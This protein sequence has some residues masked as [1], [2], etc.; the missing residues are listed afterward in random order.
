MICWQKSKAGFTLIELMI[1]V[2]LMLVLVSAVVMVFSHTSTV[3][4]IS[5]AKMSVYQ[6]ARAALDIM[7]KELTS[8]DNTPLTGYTG[9]AYD[10]F[11][12]AYGGTVAAGGRFQF[13]TN[14]FWIS[15]SSRQ[16]GMAVVDYSLQMVPGYNVYNI[17]R[18]V[19]RI[20]ISGT[21][22][23]LVDVSN[24]ILAQYVANDPN[25]FQIDC[26]EYDAAGSQ[27]RQYPTTAYPQTQPGDNKLPGA[28]RIT[29]KFTD[30]ERRILRSLSRTIWI[31]KVSS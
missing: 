23:T 12:V 16:N 4:S 20:N 28:V 29:I 17:M 10:G 30:R 13:K 8:S 21:T 27:W 14:T 1:S 2:A 5:E 22:T 24:D 7:A 6:N 15:G 25:C 3:F 19:R 26:F 31:P 9:G 11:N 18:R